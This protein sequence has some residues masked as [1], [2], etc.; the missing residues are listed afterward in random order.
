MQPQMTL[1]ESTIIAQWE[2]RGCLFAR[3][4]EEANTFLPE[5][6][7]SGG[8]GG[9]DICLNGLQVEQLLVRVGRS[10]RICRWFQ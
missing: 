8:G 10:C 2:H 9:G 5:P 3:D 1:A 4:T 6:G 7:L